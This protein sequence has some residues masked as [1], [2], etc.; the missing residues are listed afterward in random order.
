LEYAI[1][2]YAIA[3]FAG[4][5][6]RSDLAE[7]YARRAMQWRNTFNPATGYI[8]SRTSSG[9]FPNADHSHQCC[10]FVEGNAAQ[11]TW[12]VPFDVTGI[13]T[14]LGGND[15]AARRLDDLF[16]ELNAGPN[17]PHAWIGNEPGLWSPWAYTF[18]GAP[19]R[20]QAVVRR[21]QRELF[22]ATPG[23]LPGNDDGGTT[24]A[25][26]V[27]SALGLYPSVPGMGGLTVGSPIFDT[28]TVRLASGG[29]LRIVAHDAA[30]ERPYVRR[31]TV[32]GSDFVGV[33]LD[34]SQLTGGARLEFWLD[35][36]P[37]T[38]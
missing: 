26:Y 24:S 12:T 30:P 7:K 34:W 17:R 22:D 27:F 18:L 4:V 16:A 21:I 31:L 25:W 35:A 13:A 33:W 28:A 23:G 6:G 14:A 9:L 36:T 8:E 3:Q 5:L 37:G 32:N 1:D 38:A 2:D 10:G 20:T 15:V 29:E 11:Y 19:S